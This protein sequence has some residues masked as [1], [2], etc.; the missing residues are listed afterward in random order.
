MTIINTNSPTP[1]TSAAETPQPG[2]MLEPEVVVDQLRAI[3]NQIADVTPLTAEQRKA[4]RNITGRV[5]N[6]ILQESTNLIGAADLVQA[7][8]GQPPA[9]VRALNEESNRWTAVESELRT[10]LNAIAGANL[11][12]RQRLALIAGR[13]YDVGTALAKD[14]EHA[15]LVPHVV[16]IKRLRRLARGKKKKQ[17]QQDPQQPATPSTES[18]TQTPKQ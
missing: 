17:P 12:R 6:E 8:V 7:S 15:I 1:A 2:T 18:K 10:M 9:D 3:R 16:E 14:P 4:V 5:T 13:A 11:I